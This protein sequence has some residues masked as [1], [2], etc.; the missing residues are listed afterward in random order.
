MLHSLAVN[1][2]QEEAPTEKGQM[3]EMGLSLFPC[4]AK[5]SYPLMMLLHLLPVGLAPLS[6]VVLPHRVFV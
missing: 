3:K 6:S 2:I 4:S 5:E 1:L